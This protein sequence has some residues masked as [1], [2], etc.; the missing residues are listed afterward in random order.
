MYAEID[1]Y[2]EQSVKTQ[3]KGE[4]TLGL[5]WDINE[6]C[7][8]RS[9]GQLNRGVLV[10]VTMDADSCVANVFFID[11]GET[12]KY[13]TDDIH[14]IPDT[15]AN[16]MPP[17]AIRCCLYGICS[18]TDSKTWSAKDIDGIYD[19]IMESPQN[20]LYAY[21]VATQSVN[22]EILHDVEQ[23]HL[24]IILIDA[25]NRNINETA[26]KMNFAKFDKRFESQFHQIC[27]ELKVIEEADDNIAVNKDDDSDW[28]DLIDEKNIKPQ[29]SFT[30][31]DPTNDSNG[32]DI[33]EV[34]EN[35]SD[36]EAQAFFTHLLG[37][38]EH[39]PPREMGKKS[40]EEIEPGLQPNKDVAP[41]ETSQTHA[42]S[43]KTTN[44]DY[45]LVYQYKRPTILW[46]QSEENIRLQISAIENCKYNLEI[47]SDS[48]IYR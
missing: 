12:F 23:Q 43:T 33:D 48:F 39:E 42:E 45:R 7:L 41:I 30:K 4:T 24:K 46:Q 13:D 3:A 31:E 27:K 36:G 34:E 21:V 32:F 5:D 22:S 11:T 44:G 29:K 40:L 10:D 6:P 38:K 2:D 14:R 18:V 20:G 15:I 17:Q 9:N 35:L 28:E 47:G 19:L 1:E 16:M 26:V 25:N 37:K 8:V